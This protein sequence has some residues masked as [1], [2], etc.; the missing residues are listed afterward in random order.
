M[1]PWKKPTKDAEQKVFQI[2]MCDLVDELVK[3]HFEQPKQGITF[4]KDKILYNNVM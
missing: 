3:R 4:F 2:T 1:S